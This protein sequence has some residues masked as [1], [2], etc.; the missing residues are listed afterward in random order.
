M[1][2]YD[3]CRIDINPF[4]ISLYS[5]GKGLQMRKPNIDAKKLWNTISPYLLCGFWLT[6]L[7]AGAISARMCAE[8]LASLIRSAA[9]ASVSITGILMVGILPILL[10]AYAVYFSE[11]WLLLIISMGKSFSFAF[12]GCGVSLAFGQSSW[13]VRFLFL[14]SDLL[15][16]PLLL[17]FW[18]HHIKGNNPVKRKG[19]LPYLFTAGIVCWVDY[20]FI[21]PFLV[22]VMNR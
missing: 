8:S 17:S 13:L 1:M 19:L 4:R 16:M 6:G 22:T 18:L 2:P 10:S 7:L 3:L 15:L 5:A 12:C 20:R 11:P 9:S 21:A 14:F